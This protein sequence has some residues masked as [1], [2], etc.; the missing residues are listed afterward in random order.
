MA[1]TELRKIAKMLREGG[2]SYK[3][4]AGKLDVS[5]STVSLWCRDIQLSGEKILELERRARDPH[6]GRRWDYLTRVKE[7]TAEEVRRLVGQ[8]KE[9]VG[10]LDK[11]DTF[12]AGVALYWA[13]GF[14]K[15][16][17]VGFSNTDPEMVKFILGWFVDCL[18]VEK[19]RL[20][21]RVVINQSH[22]D[23]VGEITEYWSKITGISIRYFYNPTFQKVTWNKVYEDPSAYHGV[24]RVRVL[25]STN[26][27]RKIMGMIQGLKL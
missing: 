26:L 15:D 18:G 8:G 16:K 19:D 5:T 14:K 2:Q 11:R 27:L 17:M 24:L 1:K 22:K 3:E 21:L 13:E 6:Y 4:I 9:E 23:R 12:I 10:S 20:R 25:K 7:R